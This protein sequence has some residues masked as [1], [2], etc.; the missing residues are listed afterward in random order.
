MAVAVLDVGVFLLVSREASLTSTVALAEQS[1]QVVAAQLSL[2]GATGYG[3]LIA[4]SQRSGLGELTLYSPSGEVL[5]GVPAPRPSELG[6]VFATRER[7]TAV[8]DG[9][10]RVVEPVGGPGRPTA[11]LQ[12]E[13]PV[14]AGGA[15]S[16]MLVA[17]HGGLSALALVVFGAVLFQRSLLRPM[18]QV[19]EGAARI[20]RGDFGVE[21]SEDAPTE[22]AQLAASL[23]EVS[24]ALQQY[25][26]RTSEQ[27]EHLQVANRDLRQAQ[28]ALVQTEKLASIG[29]LAAGLAHELGNPLT[30]VRSYMELLRAEVKGE[31]LVPELLARCQV[32]VE[33]MH[34][35]LRDLLD[36]AR[37]GER[38]FGRVAIPGLLAEVAR[39]VRHL[40]A[41]R[42]VEV[43]V[44]APP[45]LEVEGDGD[46]LHQ[47]LL[48]LLLNAT[49]AGA[50]RILLR[51]QRT[52]E[53][54]QLL[55]VDNGHGITVED[56]SKI[57]EPFY[58]TRPV[59]AGTGLGLAV[60]HQVVQQHGGR[61]TVVSQPGKGATFCIHL[62]LGRG[63]P[64]ARGL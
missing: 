4:T 20:A 44:E 63:L 26:A 9:K 49:E 19:R 36:F 61:L 51:G 29:R 50:T 52:A 32:D 34:A 2:T 40:P 30:A 24:R 23:N 62:P 37:S 18:E 60:A 16:W 33:R 53:E 1:A 35:I 54:V 25:R 21:V 7:Q 12:V 48:N 46:R 41:F 38:V 22:L 14:A 13:L 57:F 27:L 43:R 3:A 47:I 58:T 42:E 39:T 15:P 8:A 64:A 56:Q 45:G 11:V 17:V 6:A 59:G 31:G 5:A 55:C 28:E 10:V